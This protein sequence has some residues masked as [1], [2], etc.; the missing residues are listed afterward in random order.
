MI[1]RLMTDSGYWIM[2]NQ[3]IVE[4]GSGLQGEI[5]PKKDCGLNLMSEHS[6]GSNIFYPKHETPEP[7]APEI[8][9]ESIAR[10]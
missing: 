4:G 9:T 3:V 10:I 7:P 1:L 5:S 6:S 2:I 8:R